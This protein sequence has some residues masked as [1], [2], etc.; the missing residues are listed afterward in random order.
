[1]EKTLRTF[2]AFELPS[3]VKERAAALQDA[4][5]ARGLKL[6]W[7]KPNNLHLTL[8][9]LG[10]TPEANVPEIVRCIHRTAEQ[11]PPLEMTLQGMGV[12][13]GIKRPR[14][15]WVGFGGQMDRLAG[16]HRKLEDQLDKLGFEREKRR[17]K[18]HLTLA[19]IKRAVDAGKLLESMTSVGDFPAERFTAD[20]L[21]LYKSDLRP[22]GAEYSA[23]ASAKLDATPGEPGEY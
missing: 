15:L 12:F 17:F 21:V 18:P 4:L 13:P 10:N 7:V 16:L 9:F 8:K 1:M 19:R 2:V 23:L 22:S 11:Q 5:K 3:L 14:V 20:K 6:Q